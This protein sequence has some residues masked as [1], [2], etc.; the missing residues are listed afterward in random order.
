MLTWLRT[1]FGT[2]VI[3]GIVIFI[4]FVFVF[5]GVF[6]P[7]PLKGLHQGSV[8]GSVNGESI[9]MA[10][11]Q[12]ALNR[13][14]EFFKNLGGGQ[15]TPEQLR[16]FGIYQ[17]VFN[18]LVTR[19]LLSQAA[20]DAGLVV[21]DEE[22]RETIREIPAF[23][24]DG[25]FDPQAYREVLEANRYTP[26]S[27]ETQ[28]RE[29]LTV[30]VWNEHFRERVKVSEE[31]VKNEYLVKENQREIKYALIPRDAVKKTIDIPAKEIKE[32]LADEKNKNL[33][34]SRYEM[35]K[36]S[37]YKG[38]TLEQ[39]QNQIA[40]EM[41]AGNKAQEVTKKGQALAKKAAERLDATKASDSRVKSALKPLDVEVKTTGMVSRKTESIPGVGSAEQL[42][43]D[44]F[45]EKS[46]I[47]PAQ[48]GKA[49]VYDVASG[50]L[51]AVV[52]DV[53]KPNLS[54]LAEKNKL[55]IRKELLAQKEREL[56]EGWLK[57]LQENARIER[58]EAI[59]SGE[60]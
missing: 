7:S 11:F 56:F 40:R 58:N 60:A 32:Y 34:K 19:K 12:Q 26:G 10:E 15:M 50:W 43:N 45:A 20:K 13:R 55:E 53:K 46:P 48:G 9:S 38:K 41:I 21:S 49:K 6:T 44:A 57:K 27:F 33:V 23:Q 8:A 4:G 52:S 28:L 39:V 14:M 35:A 2:V 5:S 30:Q 47:N 24:R 18:D 3:L 22:L 54:R 17:S 51:V 42:L 29:D 16:A 31:E 25:K 1:K 36:E 37:A 59:I